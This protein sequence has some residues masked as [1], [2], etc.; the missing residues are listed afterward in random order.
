MTW[1][2]QVSDDTKPEHVYELL[3]HHRLLPQSEVMAASICNGLGSGT[4]Y[5]LMDGDTTVANLFVT[6][7]APMEIAQLDLIPVVQFFRTGFDAPL[8]KS[9]MPILK[10][11]FEEEKVRRIESS[12]PAS[13]S[14]TK[15]ALC[16]L[17]FKPEGRLREGIVLYGKEPEDI[18]MLG[19]MPYDMPQ[20]ED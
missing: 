5:M 8:R 13:R 6:G 14:R 17:G 19:M 16:S 12:I 18:R 1:V 15:R 9:V 2:L 4:R 11:L 3:K 10:A 7:V 20:T